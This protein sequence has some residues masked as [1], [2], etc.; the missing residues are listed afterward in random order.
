M[1]KLLLLAG[2]FFAC[3]VAQAQLSYLDTSFNHTGKRTQ[4][5]SKI[6]NW[7]SSVALDSS[8]NILVAGYAYLSKWQFALMRLRPDGSLDTSLRHTGMLISP[9]PYKVDMANSIAVSPNQNITLAGFSSDG[10]TDF[11]AV[12]RYLPDGSPDSSFGVNGVVYTAGLLEGRAYSVLVQPDRK[13]L[14][15]GVSYVGGLSGMTLLR[16]LEDG[17]PDS[18]FGNG[19][20]VFTRVLG[21]PG[22]VRTMS[23]LP[24][25]RVLAGGV[26]FPGVGQ[27]FALARFHT[28]GSPDT[29]FAAV[30]LMQLPVGPAGSEIKSLLLRPD[31]AVIAV[32]E[33]D[34]GSPLVKKI[35]MAC[36]LPDGSLDAGFGIGGK[37]LP[38]TGLK[39]MFVAGAV[40]LSNGRIVVGGVASDGM[41]DNFSLARYLPDGSTDTAFNKSG[42]LL[43][44]V[45]NSYS[46]ITGLVIQPDDRIVAAG[47]CWG[48]AAANEF[49]VARYLPDALPIPNG[50]YRLP[51][52]IR[53]AR[54]YP[55]PAS[56]FLELSYHCST[57]SPQKIRLT[58]LQGKTLQ[59]WTDLPTGASAYRSIRLQLPAHLPGGTYYISVGEEA[60]PLKFLKL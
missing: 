48:Q 17:R 40:Q 19:G 54:I 26:A 3:I 50:I 11:F 9:T 33:A 41:K 39:D 34:A 35:A 29:S 1:R 22:F 42:S 21:D 7:G 6:Q 58:D 57:Y 51:A 59:T 20:I 23:L 45:G 24:D 25:G 28:D 52:G 12:M 56:S 32:G 60:F 55:N 36:I 4:E 15:G 13:T 38:T 8:G 10:T 16:L 5:L 37:V 14:L 18:S 53:E 30:G 2:A 46:Y 43:T 47:W 27:V 49:A 31:G 44:T